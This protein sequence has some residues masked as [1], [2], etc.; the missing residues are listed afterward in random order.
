MTDR[1]ALYNKALLACNEPRLASLAEDRKPRR[2][3]DEVWDGGWVKYC[4][5]QGAWEFA[6]RT[7]RIEVDEAFSTPDFGYQYAFEIPTDYVT[8]IAVCADEFFRQPLLRYAHEAGHWFADIEPLFVQFVS[9]DETYGGD[10]SRWSESFTDY[11]ANYGA[12]K[13]IGSLGGEKTEQVKVLLGPAGYPERGALRISLHHAKSMSARTQPTRFP[14][15]GSWTRARRGARGGG[16]FGD[17]GSSSQLI[18]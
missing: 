18:G 4:L 9:S 6:M 15:E 13:I 8:T 14:A 10:L 16:R 11:A 17:G 12:S 3:L 1:L 2:I 7:A 5:E